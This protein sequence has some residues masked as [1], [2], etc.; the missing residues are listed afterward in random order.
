M[1]LLILLLLF[2]TLLFSQSVVH[3]I[4]GKVFD[5]DTYVII[6]KDTALARKATL[7]IVEESVETE[8]F[9]NRALTIF[10]MGYPVVLWIPS[11]PKNIEEYSILNHEILHV[12]SSILKWAGVP[13][14]DDTEEVYGHMMQYYSKEIYK[15]MR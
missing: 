5:L 15:L 13:L 12:V 14:S 9:Q 8:D 1:K 2:P 4:E 11:K 6:T 3:K 10:Q 7:M